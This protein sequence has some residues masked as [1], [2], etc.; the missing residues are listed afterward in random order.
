[1]SSIASSEVSRLDV[2]VYLQ[3]GVFYQTLNSE[4]GDSSA[5]SVPSNCVKGDT[6]V[7]TTE[8]LVHLLNSLRFWGVDELPLADIAPFLLADNAAD[9]EVIAYIEN[10]PTLSIIIALRNTD[11]HS[12]ISHAITLGSVEVV[13]YL[14]G[15]KRTWPGNVA[16]ELAAKN[17]HLSMLKFILQRNN[18]LSQNT[19]SVAVDAGHADC[20]QFAYENGGCW[21]PSGLSHIA[22][23]KGHLQCVKYLHSV[24][25]VDAGGN[26][27]S[28]AADSGSVEMV[29][30]MRGLGCAWSATTTC[31]AARNGHLL[32][33]C[34]PVEL[35][36]ACVGLIP[37]TAR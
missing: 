15:C 22:V 9:N 4:E 31:A 14:D 2:P 5:I 11:P 36:A 1:M 32:A 33:V 28:V 17:G 6:T 18:H 37:H 27:C 21:N 13:R 10:F 7:A 26:L 8:D 20:L 24:G 19:A 25:L 35:K 12:W 30:Y 3:G 16:S 34:D 23:Q 29:I